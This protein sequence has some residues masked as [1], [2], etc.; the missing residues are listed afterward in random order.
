MKIKSC[1][2][3]VALTPLLVFAQ[4]RESGP[5]GMGAPKSAFGP[6][7]GLAGG[8]PNAL[9]SNTNSQNDISPSSK[10]GDNTQANIS[11]SSKSGNNTQVSTSNKS[12]DTNVKSGSVNANVK[13]SGNGNKSGNTVNI[14][15]G[16]TNNVV[17]VVPPPN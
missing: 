16:N 3:L 11:P 10:S 7:P 15:T 6:A 8:T 9:I 17:I 12:G 1:I 5:G 2:A 13:N 14:D 4:A